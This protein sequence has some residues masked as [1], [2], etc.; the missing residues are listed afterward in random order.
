[1]ALLN[2]SI[3]SHA[4]HS[5]IAFNVCLPTPT[6][7]DPVRYATLK[8]DYGYDKGLPV[9]ILLH[10][11]FGDANSWMRFSCVDRYAQDRKIAVVACSAGNN[12]YQ[13]MPGGLPYETFFTEEL[14][15]YLRALFPIS[16]RR[17]DTFI[18][19]FSMGGYGAWHLGLLA[20]E[21]FS[22]AASMSGALDIVGLYEAQKSNPAHSNDPFNWKAMFGDPDH[23]SGS[24]SDLFAQYEAC[25][26][27]GCVPELYQ[28][29]G[30]EDFL[31]Q[32]NLIVR[33]RMEKLGAKITY[34]EG[35]GGH[36]WNFW[37]Q[38]VQEMLDWFLKDREK[39]ESAVIMW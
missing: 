21:V 33:E 4:L 36:D 15:A 3:F 12:F 14:P 2:C 18:G 11:M 29:C 31:Y 38:R 26:A 9:A 13:N 25:A 32:T 35:P 27:R 23:L 24:S 37:D 5:N 6:S 16:P 30:T 17:E 20:P 19:G 39:A 22:K 8:Q 34:T 10:G 7:G 1:M 28:T